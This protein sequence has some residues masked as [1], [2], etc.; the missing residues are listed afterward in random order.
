VAAGRSSAARGPAPAGGAPADAEGGPA[1]DR[2][3]IARW[4]ANYRSE[5]DSAALY[6]LLARAESDDRLRGLYERLAAT[7][8]RHREVWRAKLGQAGEDVSRL[9]P[10]RRVRVLG[11]LARV[12]GPR[13]VAPLARAAEAAA[14]AGYAS[15]P[16]AVA[17]GM[18]ADERSH[19]RIF[20]ALGAAGGAGAAEILRIEG[21][22]RGGAGNTLRA[23]VLGANDGLVSNLSLVMGVAG[24]DP[25]RDVILLAGVS[26]L[27]AGALSMAL[28]EWI[29]VRSSQ[30]ALERQ[31]E[32]ERVELA[33]IPEEEREEL[34]L[35]YQAKGLPRD[36][37][38]RM[39]SRILARPETALATLVREELGLD[40]GET[41]SP[42]KAAASSFLLFVTGAVVPVLPYLVGGGAGAVAGSAVLSAAGLF[43]L[44]AATTLFTGRGV[45][46]AGLRQVGIG[47]AAA[48]VTFGIGR[49]V[50]V[51][52]GIG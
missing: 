10:S 50:G 28:G 43:A 22:H 49:A 37:A 41:G 25:G 36:E 32:V 45:A 17:L 21:R 30:E 27:L 24:A 35:I 1:P 38:E 18:H 6:R 19:A 13:A 9:G 5:L 42:W 46:A 12:A 52:A 3:R 7:E 4:R 14:D 16:E 29:S 8:D 44:G 31:I 23:A 2:A 40:P 39:A 48:A 20:A 34:A 15:Q 51:A 33:E 47:L 11:A 26:G